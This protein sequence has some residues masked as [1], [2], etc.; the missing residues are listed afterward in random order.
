MRRMEQRWCSHRLGGTFRAAQVGFDLDDQIGHQRPRPPCDVDRAARVKVDSR[1][2]YGSTL[3][4]LATTRSMWPA[5]WRLGHQPLWRIS[6]GA[7][8]QAPQVRQTK[9]VKRSGG[10]C[11]GGRYLLGMRADHSRGGAPGGPGDATSASAPTPICLSGSRVLRE[12]RQGSGGLR[13]L[14]S[15]RRSRFSTRIPRYPRKSNQTARRG[16]LWGIWVRACRRAPRLAACPG[17]TE[18]RR[19]RGALSG[20][21]LPTPGSYEVSWRWTDS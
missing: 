4:G 20:R 19:E 13:T 11:R 3:T 6:S 14:S 15:S 7:R 9:S 18:G 17:V 12:E 21:R 1:R 10:G 2:T 16:S 8:A 5:S